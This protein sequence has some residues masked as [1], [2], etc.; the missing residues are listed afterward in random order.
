MIKFLIAAALLAASAAH[1]APL[2]YNP[3]SV[4]DEAFVVRTVICLREAAAIRLRQG[5]RDD[6]EIAAWAVQVCAIPLGRFMVARMGFTQDDAA[7]YLFAM[8]RA[9][10]HETPGV[11]GR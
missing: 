7:T 5:E 3:Q 11:R 1:G 8:A 9:A 2:T 6:N 10:V 4:P